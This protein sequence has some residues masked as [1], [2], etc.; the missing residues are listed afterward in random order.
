MLVNVLVLAGGLFLLLRGADALVRGASS[1]ARR[2]GISAL[3]VGLTVVAFGTSAPEL[4]VNLVSVARGSTDIAFGNIVGSNIANILLILGVAG[5]IFPLSVGHTTTWKEIPFAVLAALL[6]VAFGSDRLLDGSAADMIGRTDGLAFL[7]LFVVFLYYVYGIA[8]QSGDRGEPIETYSTARS[9]L[10]TAGGIVGLAVGAPLIVDS[11]TKMALAIGIS[12]HLVAMSV[13][14]V[15]T[16]LPELAT[17]ITA[18]LRKH[19]DIA[20]G[21]VV[22][23]N[24][25]NVFLI[26]GVSSVLRPLPVGPDAMRDAVVAL[27]A[28]VTLFAFLFVGGRQRVDRWQGLVFVL[29]YVS[30]IAYLFLA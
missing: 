8:R 28:S 17:S 3:V 27:L 11:A 15:G 7:G 12:E 24:I 4:V 26:L 25:F 19:S 6:V 13:V 2:L 21:N 5:V 1:L 29:A 23:S 14:A 20:V 16:S 30:Y 10:L 9:V 18:A 22:G